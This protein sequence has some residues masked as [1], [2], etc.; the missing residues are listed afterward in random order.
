M[1][2]QILG[3]GMLFVPCAFLLSPSFPLL[4]LH[5]GCWLQQA[6]LC[7]SFAFAYTRPYCHQDLQTHAEMKEEVLDVCHTLSPRDWLTF[8]RCLWS[9]HC[10]KSVVYRW[11]SASAG[12]T[13][14][15]CDSQW[16]DTFK[17]LLFTNCS[18]FYKTYWKQL[19]LPCIH[20]ILPCDVNS[21]NVVNDGQCWDYWPFTANTNIAVDH[22]FF[23]RHRHV[24]E[25]KW[26]QA[27]SK[28]A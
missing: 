8:R 18:T 2:N 27:C 16:G 13:D 15:L 9:E 25:T 14:V 20:Y 12:M 24:L 3:E 28:D 11:A 6:I 23:H 17:W 1:R 26:L 21:P 10:F 7:S 5:V 19:I 22:P 4:L